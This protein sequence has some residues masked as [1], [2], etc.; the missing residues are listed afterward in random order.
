MACGSCSLWLLWPVVLEA[1]EFLTA[2][3]CGSCGCSLCFL[4]LWPVVLVAAEC[5]SCSC[6]LWFLHLQ[7]VVLVSV[8]RGS[9]GCSL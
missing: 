6:G 3:D 8:A 7:P 1:A 2:V 9:C 5:R 4:Q